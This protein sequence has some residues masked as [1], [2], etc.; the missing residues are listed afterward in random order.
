M[1][2]QLELDKKM[3]NHKR[4]RNR[5]AELE[6]TIADIFP[7]CNLDALLGTLNTFFKDG[8]NDGY[9]YYVDDVTVDIIEIIGLFEGVLIGLAGEVNSSKYKEMVLD[10]IGWNLEYHYLTSDSDGAPFKELFAFNIVVFILNNWREMGGVNI[11]EDIISVVIE[12]ALKHK[13]VLYEK[14]KLL[15]KSDSYGF[16]NT[17][18][19][20]KEKDSYSSNLLLSL[21]IFSEEKDLFVFNKLIS[22]SIIDMLV[23]E[24]DAADDNHSIRDL[25][26]SN[27]QKGVGYEDE[28][29]GL[30]RESG[31]TALETP[32]SGDAGADIIATKRGLKVAVQCKNWSGNV[33]T[34]AIQEVISAKGYYDADFAIL[35]TETNIT[36]QAEVVAEK[37]K[38]IVIR[39]SDI[40]ELEVLIVKKLI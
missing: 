25:E 31:W 4:L 37:L 16:A 6:A 24:V 35:L 33:G 21:G 7:S 34:T 1:L 23:S 12:Y 32:K 14:K 13:H 27:Y 9:I 26:K 19:W 22:N 10:I 8:D 28:C 29:I 38:V 15:V 11:N 20:D 2:G 17:D 39:K 36:R 3:D 30:F 18:S 40:P 5:V